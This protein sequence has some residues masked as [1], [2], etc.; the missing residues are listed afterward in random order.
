MIKFTICYEK[1]N[2]QLYCRVQTEKQN[3]LTTV[4]R[5]L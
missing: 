5:R 2:E 3:K 4:I 1:G